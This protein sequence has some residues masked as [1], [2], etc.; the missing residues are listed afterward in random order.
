MSYKLCNFFIFIIIHC[1]KLNN[2]IRFIKKAFLDT[3]EIGTN[4]SWIISCKEK[5][6]LENLY[7]KK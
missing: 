7:N 2:L 5:K 6:I 1:I 3:N 4:E